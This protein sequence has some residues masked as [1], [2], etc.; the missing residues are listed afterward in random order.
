MRAQGSLT[1]VSTPY[2]GGGRSRATTD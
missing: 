1:V 2:G